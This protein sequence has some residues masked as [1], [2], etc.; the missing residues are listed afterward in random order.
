MALCHLPCFGEH[1]CPQGEMSLLLP[2]HSWHD[3][4]DQ[5]SPHAAQDTPSRVNVAGSTLT[6]GSASH[7]GSISTQKGQSNS[8][9]I[10]FLPPPFPLIPQPSQAGSPC[11][12]ENLYEKVRQRGRPPQQSLERQSALT[13]GAGTYPVPEADRDCHPCPEALPRV[14]PSPARDP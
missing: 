9:H 4:R 13:P 6:S 14:V 10:P 11:P 12:T 5:L 7:Q 8:W 2:M 1:Q 3:P